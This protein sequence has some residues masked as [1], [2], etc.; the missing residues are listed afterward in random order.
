MESPCVDSGATLRRFIH[1]SIREQL[2]AEYLASLQL[3]Q[4]IE[5]LLPHLWY[6]PDWEYTAPAAVVMH[7]QH[8]QLLQSLICRA[9]GQSHLPAALSTI[10][11]GWE[12][13]GFLA[14][15][16][17]ES[18]QADWSAT[19]ADV[20]NRA[21]VDLAMAGRFENLGGAINWMAS[22]REARRSLIKHMN[23]QS[24]GWGIARVVDGLLQL[25]PDD[26]DKRQA[27]EPLLSLLSNPTCGPIAHELVAA[28]G[29]LDPN[30]DDKRRARDALCASWPVVSTAELP[31]GSWLNWF[32]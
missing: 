26:E 9:A 8:D 17:A 22:N 21:R 15:I 25:D 16:A 11:A 5:E 30:T 29:Q 6:D 12:F 4:A 27:L 19:T 2:V 10:D 31:K 13:R 20:I 18:Y 3:D 28:I 7:P 23:V 24:D 14:R 32:I 1:R